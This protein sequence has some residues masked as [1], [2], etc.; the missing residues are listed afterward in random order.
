[1]CFRSFVIP[2]LHKTLAPSWF[3]RNRASG[4]AFCHLAREAFRSC[5]YFSPKHSLVL[6][7]FLSLRDFFNQPYLIS[8]RGV[9]DK[10][11]NASRDH[12]LTEC[13]VRLHMQR[14]RT[15]IIERGRRTQEVTSSR[16]RCSYAPVVKAPR[17]L[18]TLVSNSGRNMCANSYSNA[19]LRNRH[20]MSTLRCK[21]KYYSRSCKSCQ[22]RY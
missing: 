17:M 8:Y 6:S 16:W 9:R 18:S 19:I 5:L 14:L 3:W 2:L 4:L 10:S 22:T 12:S 20:L 1:M 7:L 13:T 11:E 15:V 21:F